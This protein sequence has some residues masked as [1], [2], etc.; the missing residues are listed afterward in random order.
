MNFSCDTISTVNKNRALTIA[1]VGFGLGSTG[2]LFTAASDRNDPDTKP[3]L[4]KGAAFLIGSIFL[5]TISA[6]IIVVLLRCK[7][8]PAA[9]PLLTASPT[10]A[11]IL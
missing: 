8:T 9:R 5:A 10:V 4:T 1:A 3:G 6:I 2:A 7:E 11:E